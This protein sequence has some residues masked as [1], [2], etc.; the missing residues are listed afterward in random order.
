LVYRGDVDLSAHE[1]FNEWY[2]DEAEGFEVN[3]DPTKKLK[4]D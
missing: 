1:K 4:K 2:Y 3:N